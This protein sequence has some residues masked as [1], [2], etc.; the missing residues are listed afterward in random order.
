MQGIAAGN[1]GHSH[2]LIHRRQ[3]TAFAK[4]EV[5]VCG[6]FWFRVIRDVF[7]S[8]VWQIVRESHKFLIKIWIGFSEH[9]KSPHQATAIGYI[10]CAVQSQNSS[11]FFAVIIPGLDVTVGQDPRQSQKDTSQGLGTSTRAFFASL[12]VAHA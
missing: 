1:L 2:G 12:Q 5:A 11:Q 3:L 7:F 10:L 4:D 8:E 9:L 6:S